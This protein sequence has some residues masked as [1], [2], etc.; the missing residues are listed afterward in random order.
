LT[1]PAAP[2]Y[3]SYV[4]HGRYAMTTV[5]DVLIKAQHVAVGPEAP[6]YRA[7]ELMSQKHVGALMV[8]TKTGT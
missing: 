6:V 1:L 7:L 3:A 8:L 5:R 4:Y 2:D